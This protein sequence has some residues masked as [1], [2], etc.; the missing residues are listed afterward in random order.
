MYDAA[1]REDDDDGRKFAYRSL[2]VGDGDVVRMELVV[3]SVGDTLRCFDE[4][5]TLCKRGG[6]YADFN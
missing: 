5:A 6:T 2:C 4:A 1:V 3:E